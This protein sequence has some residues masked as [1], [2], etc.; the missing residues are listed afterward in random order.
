MRSDR[1][2][3]LVE[4]TIVLMVVSVLAA[5]L[6]PPVRN[7]VITTQQAAARSDVDAIGSALTRFLLDTGEQWI[8]RDGNGTVATARPSHAAGN[9]VD[10]LVSDGTIPA[11]AVTRVSPGVDWSAAVNDAAVQ[12]LDY[13]LVSNTPSNLAANAYRTAA[14]MS[15]ATEFDPDGGALFNGEHAWRGAYL[16]G[17]IGADPWGAR[18]AVNVEFLARDQGAGPSGHV[19]D[20][21]VLSA[22]SN[23]IVET[24]VDADGAPAGDDVIAVLHGGTR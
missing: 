2:L 8:L 13:F 23:G 24:R 18:Y 21:L 11:V 19:N 20:T 3:S 9:R 10:L 4:A 5:I 22:G 16:P 15:V 14:A 7:Y 1:G 17:P 12:D 6:A